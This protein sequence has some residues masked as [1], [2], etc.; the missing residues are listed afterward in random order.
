MSQIIFTMNNIVQNSYNNEMV[1]DLPV[2]AN[3]TGCEVALTQATLFYC[4]DNISLSTYNNN[5]FSYSW[6][7]TAG[8]GYDSFDI[9]IPDGI[10]SIQ[11]IYEYA[12]YVMIENNHYATQ[13][14]SDGTTSNIFY[15]D[16]VVN[17]TAYAIQI[18][19]FNVAT[20]APS[21]VSYQFTPPTV[22][23]NPLVTFP[24][25]F[26]NIVGYSAN[27][28]T[29]ESNSGTTL[30]FTSSVAP[31]VQPSPSLLLSVTGVNNK[32]NTDPSILYCLSPT[33]S[34][35]A[36]ITVNPYPMFSPMLGGLY[37]QIRLRW[38]NASYKPIPLADPNQ[39]IIL[40]IR[41]I[42]QT[43]T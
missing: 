12:Q 7:N 37:S 13:T 23:F 4:W 25:N 27:Y 18:N 20:T 41:K 19:V 26:N 43:S 40:T 8:T 9:V 35:G 34:V 5:T 6:L 16:M 42:G 30:S 32:Y 1:Y 21:G 33:V 10:Y 29:T 2:S 38:L 36:Q 24:S 17:E 39:T 28:T 14:N 31:Q 15:W 22:Q 11:Q 3:F